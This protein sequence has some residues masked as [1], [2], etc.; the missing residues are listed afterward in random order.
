MKN[1]GGW[2][3]IELIVVIVIMGVVMTLIIPGIR[4]TIEKSRG[5]EAKEVLLKAYLGYK[6]VI[7]DGEVINNTN[8]LTWQKMG[9]TDPNTLATRNFNYQII[10][11]NNPI[12]IRAY[13]LN[14]A[15]R[16]MYIVLSPT[17]TYPQGSWQKTQPY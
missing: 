14:N 8:Q 1:R 4:D 3:L 12:V 10:A 7:D 17:W 2:T 11:A 5:A 15:S 9:M 6:R 13:R 16:W